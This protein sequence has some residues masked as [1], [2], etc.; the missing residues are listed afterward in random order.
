[1]CT[2]SWQAKNKRNIIVSISDTDSIIFDILSLLLCLCEKKRE[3][4]KEMSPMSFHNIFLPLDDILHLSTD[5]SGQ[6]LAKKLEKINLFG[7]NTG[8]DVIKCQC[9]ERSDWMLQVT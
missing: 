2:L 7:I 3:R 9:S 5:F 1:M 4:E 8:A 6:K